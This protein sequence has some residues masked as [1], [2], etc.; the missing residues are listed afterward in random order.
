[1]HDWVDGRIYNAMGGQQWY[2]I[3][4]DQAA[5]LAARGG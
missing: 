5:Q 4:I 3:T 1:V 2:N